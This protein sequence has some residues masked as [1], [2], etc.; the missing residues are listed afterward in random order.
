MEFFVNN[1]W[2]FL[3]VE[4]MMRPIFRTLGILNIIV[5]S[6]QSNVIP[7]GEGTVLLLKAV[8]AGLIFREGFL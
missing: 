5:W 2:A 8:C 3:N 4:W 1:S 6:T 7:L